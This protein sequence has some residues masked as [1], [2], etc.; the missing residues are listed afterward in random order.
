MLPS[1]PPP[2]PPPHNYARSA[3]NS[4]TRLLNTPGHDP[5]CSREM[6]GRSLL[7]ARAEHSSRT[8]FISQGLQVIGATCN[9]CAQAAVYVCMHGRF[10]SIGNMQTCMHGN[11]SSARWATFK[12]ESNSTKTLSLVMQRECP[13]GRVIKRQVI[14]QVVQIHAGICALCSPG[15]QTRISSIEDP[16]VPHQIYPFAAAVKTI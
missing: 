7:P 15:G 9:H 2:P 4:R 1:V 13:L 5:M 3:C 11:P 12:M 10:C 14:L 16:G 6:L 8:Y